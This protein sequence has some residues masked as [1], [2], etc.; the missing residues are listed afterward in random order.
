MCVPSTKLALVLRLNHDR[1]WYWTYKISKTFKINISIKLEPTNSEQKI[2]EKM[3]KHKQCWKKYVD[4]IM[5]PQQ[6]SFIVGKCNLIFYKFNHLSLI[7]SLHF[8]LND[9]F[10]AFDF[11]QFCVVI[12]LFIPATTAND[13]RLRRIF[14]PKFYPL[15]IFS[16]LNSWEK[17]P[18]FSILNVQC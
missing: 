9:F 1:L 6:I 14:Y 3:F 11:C 13:L 17:E 7:C 5:F 10:L 15:H 12:R 16:Y 2:T 18:V 4:T 8:T